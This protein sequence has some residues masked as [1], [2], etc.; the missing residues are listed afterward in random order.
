MVLKAGEPVKADL[1][2]L[3]FTSSLLG[4][5]GIVYIGLGQ[6]LWFR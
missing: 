4:F 6:R 3:A 2:V 1:F 5:A